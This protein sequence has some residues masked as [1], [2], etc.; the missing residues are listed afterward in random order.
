MVLFVVAVASDGRQTPQ[1]SNGG[2]AMWGPPS[3][4]YPAPSPDPNYPYYYAPNSPQNPEQQQQ[5]WDHYNAMCSYVAEVNQ[6]YGYPPYGYPPPL[7]TPP[8]VPHY[9]SDSDECGYSSTDEMNYYAAYFKKYPPPIQP[10]RNYY[11]DNRAQTP[12]IIITPSHKTESNGCVNGDLNLDPGNGVCKKD[13]FVDISPSATEESEEITDDGSDTEV[14]DEEKQRPSGLQT[15]KSVPDISIYKNSSGSDI[16]SLNSETDDVD[17][18][19]ANEEEEEEEEDEE[20]NQELPHQLSVIFEESEHSECESVK[21]S[22]HK[23]IEEVETT[24]ENESSTATL[25]NGDDTD[26]DDL[27]DTESSTVLVRLPLKLQFS[28]TENDE[29]VTT[30]TVGDSE[31]RSSPETEVREGDLIIQEI[32]KVVEEEP[33]VSVTFTIPK[34]KSKPLEEDFT[35][36]IA[37][38][39]SDKILL[40]V[41]ENA[42]GDNSMVIANRTLTDDDDV[43][44]REMSFETCDDRNTVKENIESIRRTSESPVD[45]WKELSSDNIPLKAQVQSDISVSITLSPGNLNKSGSRSPYDN[46][47]SESEE[48]RPEESDGHWEDDSSS[49]SVQTVRIGKHSGSDNFSGSE[50]ETA[51]TAEE[52]EEEVQKEMY[53]GSCDV[54]RIEN[55]KETETFSNMANNIA[56]END[57][58][59]IPIEDLLYDDSSSSEDDESSSSSISS[60]ESSDEMSEQSKEVEE[61]ATTS[62]SSSKA[63]E[64]I[65]DDVFTSESSKSE[66]N[67]HLSVEQKSK[68]I[69]E[70]SCKSQEDSEED[71]SGVTSDMSR[72]ISETD[73]DPE[74]GTELRKLTPYQRASTHS[75][76]FKLLQDECGPDDEQEDE[77]VCVEK[78]IITF[79]KERLSLPLQTSISDPDS[80][81]SSS[82]INS[83]ASPTV[84]DKLVKELVQSLLHKKKGRHFRKLPMDKLYAAAL[85][86][87]QEDMDPYDTVSST[88]DESFRH[89]PICDTNASQANINT[90]ANPSS[91]QSQELYGENYY[92]YCDY[93]NTWG[94]PHYYSN[95]EDSLGY[96]I[97]P[98][99]AFRLLQERAQT[100]HGFSSG[101]IEGLSAKCP[102]V[103]N[104]Q[105]DSKDCTVVLPSD[106]DPQVSS[107][108]KT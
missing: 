26:D 72:H 4:S 10:Y 89:S 45:F 21:K 20:E 107:S 76:L 42:E 16:Q 2:E 108:S 29:E 77:K 97:L 91:L 33:E 98:S 106:P 11:P 101:V 60:S 100:P 92:D 18:E 56:V 6:A 47:T 103:P 5:F 64:K 66:A 8:P 68:K 15:I 43:C 80:M 38:L 83:P 69:R 78:D 27:I 23:Q 96:D 3:Y 22:K 65:D 57:S 84:S 35:G 75:R 102:R 19:D 9:T 70:N 48:S 36:D 31:I 30:V 40:E 93:Y 63:E 34:K 59:R 105:D 71:D 53:R 14:E 12:Q 94:N 95:V 46:L 55:L 87:L 24:S 73:T 86:I 99:R 1:F 49:T 79:R 52:T 54:E 74:C 13:D 67:N 88:S 50:Y 58:E 81:S 51:G 90:A 82:G 39:K 104:L 28:K 17:D 7:Y 41:N 25:D 32:K 44:D 62:T 61:T 37:G 85:R